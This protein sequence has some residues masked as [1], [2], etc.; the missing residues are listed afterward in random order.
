M[1]L[2]KR[3]FN[4]FFCLGQVTGKSSSTYS[5]DIFSIITT[6]KVHLPPGVVPGYCSIYLVKMI[7]IC[8]VCMQKDAPMTV[9]ISKYILVSHVDFPVMY[10]KQGFSMETFFLGRLLYFWSAR[11]FGHNKKTKTCSFLLTLIVN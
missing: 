2:L 5:W 7:H 8:S 9:C 10:Y 3:I 6:H 1:L 4:I 11:P